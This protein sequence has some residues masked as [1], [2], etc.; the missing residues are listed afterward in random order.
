MESESQFTGQILSA[1]SPPPLMLS[2]FLHLQFMWRESPLRLFKIFHDGFSGKHDQVFVV[3][4]VLMIYSFFFPLIN[5]F[6]YV[7]WLCWV[8]IAARR[9]SLVVASGGYS[10][11]RCV[12]FSLRWLLC[13]RARALGARASGVVA[14]GL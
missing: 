12:G 14:H 11:L 8:F 10:M 3:L 2:P 1:F 9:L 5:L 7:F 4:G 13:C 6:I